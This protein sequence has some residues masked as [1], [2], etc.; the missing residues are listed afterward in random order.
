MKE[1]YVYFE[2]FGKKMKVRVKTDS[3]IEATTHVKNSVK[4]IKV[5]EAKPE[6]SKSK[7]DFI[8]DLLK[9]MGMEGFDDFFKRK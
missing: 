9:D 5:E 2:I 8:D 4:I 6:Q 1:H 3:P 7:S